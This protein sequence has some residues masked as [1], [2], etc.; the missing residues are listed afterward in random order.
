MSQIVLKTVFDTENDSVFDMR[1]GNE[2]VGILK[3]ANNKISRTEDGVETKFKTEEEFKEFLNNNQD[4][5][6]AKLGNDGT[7][8]IKYQ[9]NPKKRSTGDCSIRAYTKAEGLT[10][11][12]AYDIAMKYGKKYAGLP[13]DSIIVDKILTE[14]F[15]YNSF[16]LKRNQR[17]TINEFAASHT[18][19][20]YVVKTRGHLVAIV[21][22]FYYDSYNSGDKKVTVY[23]TKR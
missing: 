23:Y 8:W 19:G 18:V 16:S 3:I 11:D 2:S 7:R 22:G 5:V 4:I 12:D 20:T 1:S 10:W 13:D 17:M 21:N 15:N 14:E 9:P 6:F